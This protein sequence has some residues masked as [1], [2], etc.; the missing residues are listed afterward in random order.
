MDHQF[1]TPTVKSLRWARN[2]RGVFFLCS[3]PT[4]GSGPCLDWWSLGM[5]QN[6]SKT[7]SEMPS[8]DLEGEGCF[9]RY[10]RAPAPCPSCGVGAGS[11]PLPWQGLSEAVLQFFLGPE[12]PCTNVPWEPP[13]SIPPHSLYPSHFYVKCFISK[14]IFFKMFS[15]SDFLKKKTKQNTTS[16]FFSTREGVGVQPLPW[17]SP[18]W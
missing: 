8:P 16:G 13:A 14:K 15:V 7:G 4:P 9:R 18:A 6:L 3:S 17:Q 5:F 1:C 10:H 12:Y 2:S 11:P